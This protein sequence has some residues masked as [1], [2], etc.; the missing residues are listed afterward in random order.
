MLEKHPK[1]ILLNLQVQPSILAKITRA[2]VY[3][4][5]IIGKKYVRLASVTLYVDPHSKA[6]SDS[7][8]L[9]NWE[10]LISF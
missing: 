2:S 7:D 8:D 5:L 1:K 9:W 3:C 4:A 10:I 6:A